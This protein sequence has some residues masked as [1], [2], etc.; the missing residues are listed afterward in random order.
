MQTY[1]LVTPRFEFTL[2][3][4]REHDDAVYITVGNPGSRTVCVTFDVSGG[5]D[6]TLQA[7]DFH[8]TCAVRARD[9]PFGR[10]AAGTVE[11]VRGALT[12]TFALFPGV[13]LI[14]LNDKSYVPN[15][16]EN[17]L[18]P[19]RLFLAT[20]G[21]WYQRY[22]GAIPG[23]R[24]TRQLVHAY[25][26]AAATL[27]AARKQDIKTMPHAELLFTL[28]SLNLQLLSGNVWHI[29]REAAAAFDAVE[30]IKQSSR[31]SRGASRPSR[32]ASQQHPQHPQHL[33]RGGGAGLRLAL[34]RSVAD[35]E[36]FH[37][38]SRTLR[39]G[40]NRHNTILGHRK[41][42][43]RSDHAL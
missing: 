22:F 41:I 14:E 39:Q 21:T 37:A 24:A 6:A 16:T 35:I 5:V 29:T 1:H 12:A 19:E 10:G 34:E 25:T 9:N 38:H 7:V 43:Y 23:G 20:G 26:A 18:L 11:M 31:A 33:Q 15:T 40:Y 13:Q 36:M 2:R 3:L 30:L 27:T 4:Q 32:S 42:Q 28:A 17:I 8:H